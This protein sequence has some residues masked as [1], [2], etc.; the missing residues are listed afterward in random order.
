ME[1]SESILQLNKITKKIFENTKKIVKLLRWLLL[2]R[3]EE[4]RYLHVRIQNSE[5]QHFRILQ[6]TL[7]QLRR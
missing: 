1:V 2:D 3:I 6:L 5:S 4:V 7:F